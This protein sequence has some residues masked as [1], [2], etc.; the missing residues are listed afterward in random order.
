MFIDRGMDKYDVAYIYTVEYYPA[1][2]RNEIGPFAEM[3]MDIEAVILSK[4]SE[5]EKCIIYY[6]IYIESRKIAH[7]NLFVKQK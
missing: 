5:R 4:M 1:I 6:Y 3:W 2:K 7:L